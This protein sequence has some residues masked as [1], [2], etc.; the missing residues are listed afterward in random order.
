MMFSTPSFAS[1]STHP[2]EPPVPSMLD[3]LYPLSEFLRRSEP[4]P[5]AELEGGGLPMPEPFRSL[6]V[7]DSDMTSTLER[8]HGERLELRLLARRLEDESLFRQ[9]VLQGVESGKAVEFGA[10]RIDLAAFDDAPRQ[11]IME[12]KQPLGSILGQFGLTYAS[13]PRLFFHVE[14]NGHMEEVLNLSR[15]ATLYG[16]QNVLSAPDGRALAEVVEILPPV[17][18]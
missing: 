17:E 8:F 10:I 3:L 7:H 13:R 15:P 9:V 4:R 16:R 6:L 11:L 14:S 12:A 18:E 1:A 5:V 2:S